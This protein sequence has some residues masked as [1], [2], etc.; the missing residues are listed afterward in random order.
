MAYHHRSSNKQKTTGSSVNVPVV[1]NAGTESF[2]LDIDR[3]SHAVQIH[4]QEG[5]SISPTDRTADKLAE[6]NF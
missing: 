4:Q 6:R 5:L 2:I 1:E 3:M